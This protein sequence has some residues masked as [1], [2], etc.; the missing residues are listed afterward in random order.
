MGEKVKEELNIILNK[1]EYI[2]LYFDLGKS[3]EHH[4]EKLER[5]KSIKLEQGVEFET[6]RIKVLSEI[7]EKIKK[8]LSIS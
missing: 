5:Y 2:E 3:I 8:I 4:K 1:D 6:D 7:K